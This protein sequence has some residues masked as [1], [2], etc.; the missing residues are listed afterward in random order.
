MRCCH[1]NNMI[2]KGKNHD[3]KCDEIPILAG[4]ASGSRPPVEFNETLC[5]G[6]WPLGSAVR[7]AR[8][9]R[10]GVIF[11]HHRDAGGAGAHCTST[12]TPISTVL[13]RSTIPGRWSIAPPRC[14]RTQALF[15]KLGIRA[16]RGMIT[17]MEW[18]RWFK[19]AVARSPSITIPEEPYKAMS[20]VQARRWQWESGGR[21]TLSPSTIPV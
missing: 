21:I 17:T 9:E 4:R 1:T 8:S 2:K 16:R 3:I 18:A 19:T 20:R 12:A 5:S 11:E 10:A 15:I 6:G 14:L 7:P 13:E